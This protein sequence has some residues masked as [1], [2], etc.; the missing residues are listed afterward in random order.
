MLSEKGLL[1]DTPAMKLLLTIFEHGMTGIL[2]LKND[3]VLKVLYF[4]RGKMI[5]AISNSDE[6]KLENILISRELVSSNILMKVKREA[7]V[8]E[9]IGKLLVEKGL[10]T[11]EELIDSSKTQLKR[12]VMS[13]LKWKNGGFQFVKDAPPERLLSLDLNIT[14]FIV[15]YILDQMD[16]SDIWKTIGSLQVEFIKSP[17]EQKVGKY[18]LSEKQMELLNSFT[19][20]DKLETILSRYSGGHRESLLKIIYFFLVSELLIKKEFDLSDSSVFDE[21]TGFE[22]FKQADAVSPDTGFGSY[23]SPERQP[24]QAQTYELGDHGEP[25]D[26]TSRQEEEESGQEEIDSEKGTKKIKMVSLILVTFIL[27][28]SGIIL[29]LLH[30]ILTEDPIK[31]M[32]KTPGANSQD[33]ITVAEQE[34]KVETLEE[35][36]GEGEVQTPGETGEKKTD[37]KPPVEKTGKVEKKKVESKKVEKKKEE[38]PKPKLPTGKSAMAYFLEGNIITAGDVWKREIKNTGVKYSILLELDCLRK[39]VIK[40]YDQF[41][42]KKDFFILN[43]PSRGRT[44]FLVMYGKYRTH[45]EA[46]KGLNAIPRYFWQ[47][48]N[49]PEVVEVTTYLK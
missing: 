33:I 28:L 29:L 35:T 3:D 47:Q 1:K 30:L 12:I 18:P 32:T 14:D 41:K 44:C 43:R 11:L 10:I 37:E 22:S 26:L 38:K 15:D 9:S 34:P 42:S 20:E 39:S 19:G 36:P 5:W 40:A 24:D 25:F 6:D 45:S 27:V 16:I 49:P 13:V 31:K 46:T 17:D 48:Q 21:E 4:N 8:S 23:T 2:Y 7:R